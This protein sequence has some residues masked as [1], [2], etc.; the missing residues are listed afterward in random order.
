MHLLML[1]NSPCA[2]PPTLDG[3]HGHVGLLGPEREGFDLKKFLYL[4]V[5]ALVCGSA[6]AGAH[7]ISS[8]RY[9]GAGAGGNE[10]G[11][12]ALPQAA[13][14]GQGSGQSHRAVALPP[15]VLTGTRTFAQLLKQRRSVRAFA[16]TPLALQ[17]LG[18]LLWAAQGITADN[19]L[20]TTPSA[21][22]LYP[23]ELYVVAG[24]VEGLPAGVYRYEPHG[25]RLE[26]I[27]P[28]DQRGALAAATMQQ[29]WLAQAPV[30]VV[31]GAVHARTATKYRDRAGRYVSIEVGAAAENLFLQAGDLDL[32]TVIVGAFDEASV[33]RV[34]QRP[35]EVAPLLL[36]P[37]GVPATTAKQ[38]ASGGPST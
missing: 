30:V 14:R 13:T 19:H 26:I 37:V 1:L 18:Q 6:Q 36:M 27:R 7:V 20:R 34:L 4:L 9:D 12:T 25:H 33:R 31:F 10:V 29:A 3:V 32:G 17:G 22:A 15:P 24:N 8:P 5:M 35:A 38:R 16:A 23:L 11:Q 2:A 21:G 28:G